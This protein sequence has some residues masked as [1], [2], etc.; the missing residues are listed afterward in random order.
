MIKTPVIKTF[1]TYSSF[2]SS[3]IIFNII[4][5]RGFK[6]LSKSI[7]LLKASIL[8]LN[9]ALIYKEKSSFISTIISLKYKIIIIINKNVIKGLLNYLT[10]I[11]EVLKEI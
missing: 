9:T 5:K 10:A 2:I 4:K 1:I 6:E 3:F 11:K 8:S 7:S